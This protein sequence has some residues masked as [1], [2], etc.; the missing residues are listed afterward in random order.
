[1]NETAHPK[2][3]EYQRHIGGD[4]PIYQERKYAAAFSMDLSKT[5]D[6]YVMRIETFISDSPMSYLS[7][8]GIYDED[9]HVRRRIKAACE[10]AGYAWPKRPSM[11]AAAVAASILA[12]EGSHS[13]RR[14]AALHR[15]PRRRERGRDR[16]A[17]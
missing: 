16:S 6:P 15:H 17:V 3:R 10:A 7:L 5:A 13:S 4:S 2:M 11:C 14:T 12:A 9:L 1:M 8:I